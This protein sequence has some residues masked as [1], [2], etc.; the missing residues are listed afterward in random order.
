MSGSVKTQLIAHDKEV[1]T[2]TPGGL[3][4]WAG[5]NGGTNGCGYLL[6]LMA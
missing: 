4:Q 1:R 3:G 2:P 5:P 6:R